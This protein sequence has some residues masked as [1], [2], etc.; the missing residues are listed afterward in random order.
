VAASLTGTGSVLQAANL[1]TYLLSQKKYKFVRTLTAKHR[2]SKFGISL[3]FSLF[4]N[5]I[6]RDV[7]QTGRLK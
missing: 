3:V 6:D 7:A 1:A 4:G 5:H 2:N